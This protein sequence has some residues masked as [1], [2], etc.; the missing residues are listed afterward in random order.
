MTNREF[1]TT[2]IE[3]NISEEITTY[4]RESI[5]KMDKRNADRS[6]KPSKTAIANEP[7]KAAI[8]PMLTVDTDTIAADV[9]TANKISTQKAS[10]LLVQMV[11]EG[12]VVQ[13]EVKV[14]KK[15][16][17]KAYRLAQ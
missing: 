9:A 4:A 3:A 5:A 2:I 12:K 8:L 17:V 7:L 14:P 11:N 10:A 16:K 1:L 15:G 13:T 6:A